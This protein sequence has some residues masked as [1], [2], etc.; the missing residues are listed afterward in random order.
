MFN[1]LD[2]TTTR[3]LYASVRVPV[4]DGE[5]NAK[6]NQQTGEIV[7]RQV[8][9]SQVP[10]IQRYLGAFEADPIAITGSLTAE[11]PHGVQIFDLDRAWAYLPISAIAEIYGAAF[12]DGA[13]KAVN[14]QTVKAGADSAQ[15]IS[16]AN[17]EAA[18]AVAQ[19]YGL[20]LTERTTAGEDGNPIV[21][22]TM[23]LAITD[24]AVAAMLMV[25]ALKFKGRLTGLNGE[26]R[27]GTRENPLLTDLVAHIKQYGALPVKS[28]LPTQRQQERVNAGAAFASRLAPGLTASEPQQNNNR[29]QFAG[30]RG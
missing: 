8:W 29:R 26:A 15:L 25:K 18:I 22:G 4:V 11:T 6:V 16:L 30:A 3:S 14:I 24:S 23:E 7:T 20:H 21:A 13:I 9:M 1:A 27:H 28:V 10:V 19:T 2:D 12:K 5:G 17:S